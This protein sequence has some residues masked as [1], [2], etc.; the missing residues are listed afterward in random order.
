MATF[1][2]PLASNYISPLVTPEERG[3]FTVRYTI[4]YTQVAL[5]T[6]SGSGDVVSLTLGTTPQFWLVDSA[7]AFS[8]TAYSG[9][10]AMSMA[11]GTTTQT[12]A[13]IGT[14]TIVTG[15]AG[16]IGAFIPTNGIHGVNIPTSA[17]AT[18]SLTTVATFTVAGGSF[19]GLTQGNIVLQLS[20]SDLNQVY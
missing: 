14:T 7:L 3:N 18:A 2:T 12:S 5:A 1:V 11:V 19:S 16:T 8:S 13:F 10:T 4:P 9:C 15:S 6:S 20:V 17:T